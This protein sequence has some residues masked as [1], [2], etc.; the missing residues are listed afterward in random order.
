LRFSDAVRQKQK[1]SQP[2]WLT[3]PR[4]HNR[5]G[6]TYRRLNLAPPIAAARPVCICRESRDPRAWAVTLVLKIDG[7]ELGWSV[8]R[9]AVVFSADE[10]VGIGVNLLGVALL[11]CLFF[12]DISPARSAIP[13]RG[14]SSGGTV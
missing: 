5:D 6:A 3:G 14:A 12:V 8:L 13:R 9:F 4:L 11:I 10:R 1:A 2:N 7:T